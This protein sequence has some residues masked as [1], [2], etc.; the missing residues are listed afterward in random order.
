MVNIWDDHDIIDGFGSYPRLLMSCPVF[1]TIGKVAFKYYLLF[2]HQ[3][4]LE[5]ETGIEEWD[6][7]VV[8]GRDR[9]PYIGELSRSFL[10]PLGRDILFLGIPCD[11]CL[12]I[13]KGWTIGWKGRDTLSIMHLH[14]RL[15]LID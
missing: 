8:F 10:T 12:L 9:G 13:L 7:S 1:S 14:M 6:K 2:Q 5:E 15:S 4:A 3:T 11:F